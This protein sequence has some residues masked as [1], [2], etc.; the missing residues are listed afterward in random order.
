MAIPHNICVWSGF[1]KRADLYYTWAI[2][3]IGHN[4]TV[5]RKQNVHYKPTLLASLYRVVHNIKWYMYYD[6]QKKGRNK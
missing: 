6:R 5:K 3:Q 1:R 4:L 2:F